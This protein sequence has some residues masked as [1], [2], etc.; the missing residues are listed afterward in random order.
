MEASGIAIE[1]ITTFLDHMRDAYEGIIINLQTFTFDRMIL[2]EYSFNIYLKPK[3]SLPF[4][5]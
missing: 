1:D 3:V 4:Y 2:L 5:H